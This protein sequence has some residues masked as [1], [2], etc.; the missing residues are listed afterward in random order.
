MQ[1]KLNWL[2]HELRE[3]RS[4]QQQQK[5]KQLERDTYFA[6]TTTPTTADVNFTKATDYGGYDVTKG[7][8]VMADIARETE[9]LE[10][11]LN[12]KRGNL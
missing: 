9:A 4:Q 1:S 10:R 6:D 5:H 11:M 8:G 7:E 2:K 12:Q 3:Q